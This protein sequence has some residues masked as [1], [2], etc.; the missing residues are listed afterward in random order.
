MFRQEAHAEPART[1]PSPGEENG[2][3]H[4][5]V[6]AAGRLL[7]ADY[8]RQTPLASNNERAEIRY[9]PGGLVSEGLEEQP[10]VGEETCG[11]SEEQPER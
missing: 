6:P 7:G 3:D 9:H 11:T 4:R 2:G 10:T 8:S 1:T 5:Y